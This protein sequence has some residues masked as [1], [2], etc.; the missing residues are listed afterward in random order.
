[1]MAAKQIYK[2]AVAKSS[3]KVKDNRSTVNKKFGIRTS[4][5]FSRLGHSFG[6]HALSVTLPSSPMHEMKARAS[7]FVMKKKN[8]AS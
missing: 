5:D 7:R 4:A 1:M 6:H 8:S 2:R 3:M